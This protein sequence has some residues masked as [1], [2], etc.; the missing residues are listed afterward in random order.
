MGGLLA[1]QGRHD[2]AHRHPGQ[3]W[4]VVESNIKKH[5]RLNMLSHLLS[6]I[7]YEEVEPET[8][9]LPK[10]PQTGNYRRPPRELTTYVPDFAA[11]LMGTKR[12]PLV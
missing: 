2:G 12:A 3:P 1:G 4:Y 8:V 6:S 10:R 5:A 7:D 11:T 9:E